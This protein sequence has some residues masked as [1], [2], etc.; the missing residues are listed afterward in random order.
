M[1]KTK[2]VFISDIHLGSGKSY[3]WFQPQHEANLLGL[4]ES[5]VEEKDD[6]K[7][8][9]ILGDLFDTWVCP[10]DKTPPSIQDI[11]AAHPKIF[12]GLSDCVAALDNV[13]YING[14][15]DMHVSQEDIE[16]I[17]AGGKVMKRIERYHGG[18]LYAEHGH[19]FAMFNARDKL[20]DRDGLPV[21]YFISRMIAG[22]QGYTHPR[23]LFSYVDDL[24][25][26]S[27]TSRTF[28]SSVV[29]AI[30]EWAGHHLDTAFVMPRGRNKLSIR[31]VIEKYA[32]LFERWTQKFGYRYAIQSIRAELGSMGWF[33][34]RLCK[35]N[36]YQVVIMGHSH[37]SE[38]DHDRGSWL[39]ST[40]N[41]IYANSG[42]WCTPSPTFVEV[43][44]TSTGFE[45]DLYRMKNGI[46]EHVE[47]QNIGRW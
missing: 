17:R 26:A 28:T 15:H 4:F 5:I 34:D 21:G 19:R 33:A 40:N 41:R 22:K 37:V 38:T 16:G 2:R 12:K 35:R 39:L 36:G 29:E 27:F 23:A 47:N 1:G 14:N 18:L 6:I 13:F 20:H 42:Y 9:V 32:T 7:D 24:L 25:E 46:P 10:P 8:L 30:M 3:D 11:I 31:E 45:V 43:D 44:K